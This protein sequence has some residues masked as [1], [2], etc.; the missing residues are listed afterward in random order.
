MNQGLSTNIQGSE[1][2]RNAERRGSLATSVEPKKI[3]GP[4]AIVRSG[5]IVT[6]DKHATQQ[7]RTSPRR[8]FV[9]EVNG[10]L[11]IRDR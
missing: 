2:M 10:R 8:E 9:R 1:K 7:I 6:Q 5:A 4:N 11:V 3:E